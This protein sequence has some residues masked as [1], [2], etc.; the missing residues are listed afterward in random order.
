MPGLQIFSLLEL[1]FSHCVPLLE[2]QPEPCAACSIP[3]QRMLWESSV[4]DMGPKHGLSEQGAAFVKLSTK[5]QTQ[6]RR[7]AKQS[8]V[9]DKAKKDWAACTRRRGQSGQGGWEEEET[10]PLRQPLLPCIRAVGVPLWN[11][12]FWFRF[13]FV[14]RKTF[15][16]GIVWSKQRI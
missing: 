7:P 4:H 13:L 10:L 3:Q 15:A 11:K 16:W 14:F 6:R 12:M 9:I 1:D 2:K 5:S 8:G